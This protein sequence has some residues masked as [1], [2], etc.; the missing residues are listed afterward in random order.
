MEKVTFFFND[1]HIIECTKNSEVAHAVSM[2]VY[3]GCDLMVITDDDSSIYPI[4]LVPIYKTEG[5]VE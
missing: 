1:G 5:G 2:L 4:Q 3:S